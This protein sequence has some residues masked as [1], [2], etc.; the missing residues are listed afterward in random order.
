[1][2]FTYNFLHLRR[3]FLHENKYIKHFEVVVSLTQSRVLGSSLRYDTYSR[4]Y[5]AG[6]GKH[7]YIYIKEE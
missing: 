5:F 1:M 4:V 3:I 6:N 2:I 7:P